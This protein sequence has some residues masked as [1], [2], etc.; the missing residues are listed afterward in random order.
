MKCNNFLKSIFENQCVGEN[1]DNFQKLI[2]K[3]EG[4]KKNS[5]MAVVAAPAAGGASGK[6]KPPRFNAHEKQQSQRPNF[7]CPSVGPLQAAVPAF[8]IFSLQLVVRSLWQLN[9]V[10]ELAKWRW[11]TVT[12]IYQFQ[13]VLQCNVVYF[14]YS[15][16]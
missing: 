2:L 16:H 10:W 9:T 14:Q 5:H 12:K 6:R 15:M 1:F 11:A 13:N 8:R 4:Q 3:R 7:I